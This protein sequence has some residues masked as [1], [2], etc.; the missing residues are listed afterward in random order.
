MKFIKHLDSL[1][2]YLNGP[3]SRLILIGP[4]LNVKTVLPSFVGSPKLN[5]TIQLTS[6]CS[7]IILSNKGTSI[8]L[9][10]NL[11]EDGHC[12]DIPMNFPFQVA[13]HVSYEA[14]KIIVLTKEN[15]VKVVK[16]TSFG[17]N[18]TIAEN[19]PIIFNKTEKIEGMEICPS[20]KYLFLSTVKEN[21]FYDSLIILVIRKDSKLSKEGGYKID[22]FKKFQFNFSMKH[23]SKVNFKVC[24]N[25]KGGPILAVSEFAGISRVYFHE[26]NSETLKKFTNEQIFERTTV[27]Y[28]E[29]DIKNGILYLLSQEG[30]LLRIDNSEFP[31]QEEEPKCK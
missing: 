8:K 4:D 13:C 25:W 26:F 15:K 28:I 19:Q 29:S 30:N 7:P 17:F 27:N 20:Q 6:D 21:H 18:E 9:L 24:G 12:R 22:I 16:Y 1:L 31:L 10:Y 14:N 23:I 5:R 3:K 11:D 2:V